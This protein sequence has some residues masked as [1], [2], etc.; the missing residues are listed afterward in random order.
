MKMQA[1]EEQC[2]RQSLMTAQLA[3]ER[4][5][6]LGITS[7]YVSMSGQNRQPDSTRPSLYGHYNPS[8]D[9]RSRNLPPH[10]KPAKGT[11]FLGRSAPASKKGRDTMN[12][13]AL[14]AALAGSVS[15]HPEYNV[16][17][18]PLKTWGST[19]KRQPRHKT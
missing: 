7:P 9:S 8:T 10:S 4:N 5:S 15:A 11:S 18:P 13:Q 17:A 14:N 12:Q 3:E 6:V 2:H 19:G 1:L 16:S